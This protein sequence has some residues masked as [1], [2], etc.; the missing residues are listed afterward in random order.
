MN[1]RKIM[2]CLISVVTACS[3]A[4]VSAANAQTTRPAPPSGNASTMDVSKGELFRQGGSSYPR[5][6]KLEHS[7]D[8]TGHMMASMTTYVD[9][10]GRAV[11]YESSDDGASFRQVG[12]IRDPAGENKKGVCCSTLYELPSAVGDMPAGTLLW[13]GTFGVGDDADQRHASIRMWRSDDHGR[14]WN[15]MS[16]VVTPP[17]GPGVWEPEFTVAADGSLVALY[18]DDMDPVHDQK[19]VEVRSKDGRTWTDRTDI[20]MNSK[21]TVRPGMA[22]VRRLPDGTFV[23]AYEVC[24]YDPHH[25]CPTFMRTSVDGWNWGDPM[26]L[27]TE[28]VSDNKTYP[29]H[30]PTITWAP[31]G[32]DGRLVM[33]YQVLQNPDGTPAPGDG[34]TLLVNDNPKNLR[35][36]WREIPS[37]VQIKYSRGSDCR[38]FSPTLAPSADGQSVVHIATD[39]IKYIGGPC[40]AFF[41]KGPI[42]GQHAAESGQHDH[43]LLGPPAP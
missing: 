11:I 41:G 25:L 14:T 2:A 21:F 5:L 4:G 1:G 19:M 15:Y 17:Q 30:T 3:V 8:A 35:S 31:G 24:N 23:M 36:G 43:K 13:A 37:P 10:A 33:A 18:S 26:N 6:I 20:V 7:G 42:D 16:N 27:G 32:P 12:E 29:T 9:N 34:N 40:E 38:N 39:Y 22:G 28:I